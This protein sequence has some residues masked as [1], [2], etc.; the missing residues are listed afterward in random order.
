MWIFAYIFLGLFCSGVG[1]P[2]FGVELLRP[3]DGVIRF[4]LQALHLL[5]DG[6]HAVSPLV[7]TPR[8]TA[9]DAG[10]GHWDLPTGG[11]WNW[12][13]TRLHF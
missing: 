8:W 4:S 1:L 3:G 7:S 9:R 2:R 12:N 6:V 13:H 5:L 11:D 10:Q